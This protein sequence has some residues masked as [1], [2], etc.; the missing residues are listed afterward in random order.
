MLTGISCAKNNG[1]LPTLSVSLDFVG[2]VYTVNGTALAL[3][4][5]I[6]KP[7]QVS[8][9][10]LAISAGADHEVAVIGAALVAASSLA[11]RDF[12]LMVEWQETAPD[13]VVVFEASAHFGYE[14]IELWNSPNGLGFD[15]VDGKLGVVGGDLAAAWSSAPATKKCAVNY[16]R[17]GPCAVSLN[18]ASAV[19]QAAGG[20]AGAMNN[21]SLGGF[22]GTGY[23]AG[24]IRK[25]A[26][27][28]VQDD[29]ALAGLS[30]L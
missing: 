20:V 3:S 26:I 8:S 13:D 22:H 5:V 11:S 2:G 28:P 6:D 7:S 27:L 12:T 19:I 23:M 1:P 17:S 29:L 15:V 21:L 24:V 14:Y 30:A 9:A 16:R 10:G 18:G 25:L 4:A